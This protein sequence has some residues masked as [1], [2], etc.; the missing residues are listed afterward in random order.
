MTTTPLT[1]SPPKLICMTRMTYLIP[2]LALIASAL[3]PAHAAA[4]ERPATCHDLAASIRS[5]QTEVSALREARNDAREAA[6]AAG[7]TWENAEAIRNF[8]DEAATEAE[9]ARETWEARKTA[10]REAQAALIAKS[11]AVNDTIAT[12]NERCARKDSARR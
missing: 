1:Q 2:I 7:E 9:A 10:F 5:G 11:E 8:G 4:S 12:Y 6:E 3:S